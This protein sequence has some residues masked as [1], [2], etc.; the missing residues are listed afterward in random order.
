MP[1]VTTAASTVS[2]VSIAWAVFSVIGGS[3]VGAAASTIVAFVI[4]K[5][6]LRAAKEQRDEERFEKRKAFAFSLFVKMG[7]I[8][9]NF[10]TMR[11]YISEPIAQAK[12][13]GETEYFWRFVLPGANHFAPVTFSPDEMAV[14]L[15]LDGDLFNKLMRWDGIHNGMLGAFETYCARRNKFT[16]ALPA[17]MTGAEGQT[18]FDEEQF[19]HAAPRMAELDSLLAQLEEQ[20]HADT[21]AS[22]PLFERLFKLF[23]KEFGLKYTIGPNPLV[24]LPPEVTSAPPVTP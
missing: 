12:E 17:T 4:Q 18:A 24:G 22:W 5:R 16:D 11:K 20:A 10:N 21:L 19:A 9:S 8:A 6:N 13:E 2:T 1:D 7:E 3:I 14:V 15:S 23:K